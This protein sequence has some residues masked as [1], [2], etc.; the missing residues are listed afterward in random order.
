[1]KY[2]RFIEDNFL[3][4]EPQ[5]GKLVPFVFNDVQNKYYDEVLVGEYDIE[6]KGISA[7][8][9]EIIVKARRE[10]FSSLVLGIFAADDITQKNPTET[11]VVSYKD[12]ATDT[13]R[14][15]YRRFI[16]SWAALNTEQATSAEL[17]N[18]ATVLERF[19]KVAFS[20]DSTDLILRH[21]RA[22]FICGT[23][24]A[25]VGG[26]GGVLQKLLFS[27]AAYYPD[28]E[29]MTAKEIV[30]GTAQQVDKNS[31]WI[32][33]ES[34][35]N[36]IGNFFHKT[37]ELAVE[38][39]SR[40]AARF[41]GWREFYTEAQYKVID[42]EFI[43]KDMLR[44]EYP[45]T[46]ADA[47]LSSNLSFTNKAEL[48][49]LIGTSSGKYI[50]SFLTMAGV[51]YI[52]QCELMLAALLALVQSNPNRAF[53]VGID[54]AKDK[55]QTVMTVIKRRE[56][57][58]QGGIRCIAIDATGAGDFMPDWFERNS[59]YY[60]HRVKFTRPSKSIM[61]KNLQT[62]IKGRLTDV[63][64]FVTGKTFLT[65][66]WKDWFTEMVNLQKLI[67]GDL[68]VCQHPNGDEY[69]DDYPD[70]W[71]LAE[72][73]YMVINGVPEGQKPPDGDG[74]NAAGSVRRML[75]SKRKGSGGRGAGIENPM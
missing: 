49:A 15:R 69:H 71:A 22:H 10:G 14:R 28:T 12:D 25:R 48:H 16:L 63:P 65:D 43:D 9:R 57:T 75:E 1:M 7:P 37:W 19:A 60:I 54:S 27:E 39:L 50:H 6:K 34:T 67:V 5:T 31:G 4:D 74:S 30:E 73:G 56:L 70:S 8:V 53:Y 13:F 24:S 2:R 11:Q 3:I 51:N 47:F 61:Y 20:T 42:S 18:D 44:K 55:D 58:A 68:M 66:E 40:Y 33:Q 23:A 21:N 59:K 41:Y 64:E 26:R 38:G 17:Q 36:G 62:V 35:G 45:E 32:F 29:K 52:D 46:A 72:L